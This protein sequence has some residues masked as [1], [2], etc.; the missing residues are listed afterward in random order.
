MP[1]R[2]QPA[3]AVDL[4]WR[5]VAKVLGTLALVWVWFRIAELFLLV[6]VAVLLAVTL[7]PV[8]RWLERRRLPRWGAASL[9]CAV[10]LAVIVA[11]IILATTSLSAQG[12]IVT[13]RMMEA[14]HELVS[15]IPAPLQQALGG[16][17]PGE[18]AQRAIGPLLLRLTR[19]TL[20]AAFVLGL[21]LILTLYLLIEGRRTYNWL[22]AF[23]PP[24]HRRKVDE[25]ALESQR[26]IFGYVVG[27]LATSAFATAVVIVGLSVLSVPAAVLLGI[28][29]GVCDFVPVLGFIASSVPAIILA[30]TVSPVVAISVAAL[31]VSYHAVENYFIA[32]W[33]YGDRL[34][35]SNVAVVLAFAVGASIAGVIGALIALP[36]AAAYP[37]V[38]RIWLAERLG[39]RVVRE[40]AAVERRKV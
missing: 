28:V 3:L 13:T 32:P 17:T 19:G 10:L 30:L 1:L 22:L 24:S 21:A 8:V 15:R 16:G 36:I 31:Y 35:L 12:Q 25:T 26:V 9:V 11:I 2:D 20:D 14:E 38:E 34:R 39:M 5:T 6:V 7:N 23:V 27:N 18:T 40:H 33:V 4:P 29:A 37:A